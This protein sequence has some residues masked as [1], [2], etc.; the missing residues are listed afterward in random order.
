LIIDLF[1]S[2]AIMWVWE[3]KNWTNFT[4]DN[5]T[6]LPTL[7]KCI[8]AVSPLKQLSKMITLEQR[9]DWEAAVLLNETLSSAKIEGELFDRDSV[10]S[11]IVNKLGISQGNKYHQQSD[12]MVELLL[13]AIRF[14][15]DQLS[16]E[17][18][19][20]WH[21]LL[22]PKQPLVTPMKNG[23]YR[24]DKMQIL[25]GRY[26]K[27][28]V[29]YQ[30][31]G[32]NQKEVNHEMNLFLNWLNS[33]YTG[34]AYIRA[35]IAKF[36]FVT[37]HPF[38][39]GNGRLSRVIAERC[40]AEAEQTNL[41]LFSLSSVF[42]ANRNEYYQQLENQQR[43]GID[44]TNWIVWFLSR[45]EEAAINAK[46][47]FEK[48]IQTTYFWQRHQ[49][50]QFNVRQLKLLTRLLETNDFSEGI[51]RKKY[52]ALA[53]TSDATAV[54]DLSDLVEK[55]VLKSFGGGRSHRYIVIK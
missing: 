52:K 30:A 23:E 40:L 49:S 31:P 42:E 24:N 35:A 55:G 50:T 15:D 47:E 17:T 16:H 19:K 53:K 51:A 26:G 13:R 27:Q 32:I 36:W 54:R 8:Q 7:E 28:Q 43:S 37:I 11:S 33:T 20:A 38:D 45:V 14:V 5:A 46:V 2:E 41:R 3:D 44:L 34:S 1:N 18:I 29:H 4:Y 39:D 25:S 48:V 12:S 9:L 21:E 6:I 10:R 22:F